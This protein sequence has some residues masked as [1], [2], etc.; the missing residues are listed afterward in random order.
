MK[1]EDLK[2]FEV[3]FTTNLQG[4]VSSKPHRTISKI[5]SFSAIHMK[6]Y[7]L[8]KGSAKDIDSL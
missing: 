8:R 5:F 2:Y 1:T 3:Q 6:N 7:I 4:A